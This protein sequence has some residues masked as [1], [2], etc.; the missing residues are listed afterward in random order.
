[1]RQVVS[2]LLGNAIKF[3]REGG[4][5]VQVKALSVGNGV[6]SLRISVTDTGVGISDTILPGIF[7]KFTQGEG[8]TTARSGGTGLGLAIVKHVVDLLGGELGVESKA[9]EGSTFW[10]EVELPLSREAPR[11]LL[12]EELSGERVMVIDSSQTGRRI[13]GEQLAQ[14]G[15]RVASLA[16]GAEAIRQLRGAVEEDDPYR[17]AILSTQLEGMDPEAL[18][19]LVKCDPALCETDF[20]LVTPVGERGDAK[21]LE[22]IGFS[23]Y[24]VKPV[25]EAALKETLE[26]VWGARKHGVEQGIVTRHTLSDS[27]IMKAPENFDASTSTIL[28]GP[29]RG[30]RGRVLLAEDS[31]VDRSV[32]RGMLE[33]FGF[34]V[35][36]V[37]DGQEAVDAT[38]KQRY[39]AIFMDLKMP[40]VDG[41]EATERIRRQETGGTQR[42][43][44]LALSGA[45][46]EGDRERC[47][48]V[49]M[50][51][52]LAKPHT[53]D[54]FEAL[55]DKWVPKAPPPPADSDEVSG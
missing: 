36:A 53:R 35:D 3:T 34:R 8:V 13:L 49:G 20:V 43:P 9:G 29:E 44:I 38:A 46:A 10:F 7:D 39:V 27:K 11:P 31:A 51:D 54:E 12:A 16:S 2:K 23:G 40:N 18:G 55:V 47:L 22:E 1:M 15:M 21:R 17:L 5:R 42:T 50:D 33:R 45:D 14:W 26:V 48:A 28:L 25:K 32:A 6:A 4:V 41:F 37:A 19:D 24:L 30:R 52:Y